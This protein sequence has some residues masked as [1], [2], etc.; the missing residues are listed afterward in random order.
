MRPA[1]ER[2]MFCN[3]GFFNREFGCYRHSGSGRPYG[4]RDHLAFGFRLSILT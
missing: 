3:G 4:V 2:I 1:R